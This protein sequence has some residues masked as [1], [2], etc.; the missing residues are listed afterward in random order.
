MTNDEKKIS[1]QVLEQ[2]KQEEVKP[3]P[4]W[5]FLLKDWV[6]W[7]TGAIAI[8]LGALSLSVIFFVVKTNDWDIYHHITAQPF[9][10]VLESMPYLWLIVLGLFIFIAQY[11]MH[12]TNNGYRYPLS[13]VVLV[14]IGISAIGGILFSR[15]GLGKVIHESLEGR[16]PLYRQL[17]SPKTQRWAKPMDGRLAGEVLSIESDEFMLL[18]I[19]DQE[20]EVYLPEEPLFHEYLPEV[21]ERVRVLGEEFGSFT[22]KAKQILPWEMMRPGELPMR[23]QLETKLRP[24]A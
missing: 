13:A 17:A 11:Q 16:S 3:K 24:P 7:G 10:F 2:I 12:H 15:F 8:L 9:G 20:W 14:L 1:T 22:F 5:T 23:E 6:L 18:D 4:R 21:G 19:N